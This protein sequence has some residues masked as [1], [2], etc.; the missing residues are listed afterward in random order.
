MRYL[1]YL[2]F[3]LSF[4]SC[5]LFMGSHRAPFKIEDASSRKWYAGVAGGG[6]G[7]NYQFVLKVKGTPDFQVDTVW[8]G[9]RPF[10]PQ[11]I[12]M[13][14]EGYYK[15]AMTYYKRPKNIQDPQ[16]EWRWRETPLEA[17]NSPDFEGS[18]MLIYRSGGAR[19]VAIYKKEIRET[20]PLNYP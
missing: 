7:V 10:H 15:L 3:A 5:A 16:N 1:L 9:R 12:P 18:A 4:S 20:E 17:A 2:A 6:M 8:I 14:K 19:K 11:L 13:E